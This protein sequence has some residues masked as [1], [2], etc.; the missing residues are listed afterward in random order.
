MNLKSVYKQV[1]AAH[2][3]LYDCTVDV[4]RIVESVNEFGET[5]ADD[6]ETAAV[7]IYEAIPCRF[8]QASVYPPQLTPDKA[9]RK[10]I[11]YKIFLDPEP[12]IL[13]GDLLRVR[14]PQRTYP[15]YYAGLPAVYNAHQEVRVSTEREFT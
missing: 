14:H 6:A 3:V 5:I 13:A 11:D 1:Q 9:N 15:D 8:S 2:H 4:Y 7:I 12:Q 10:V